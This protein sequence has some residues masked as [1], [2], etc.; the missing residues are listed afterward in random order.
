MST[1]RLY[2]GNLPYNVAE[3]DLVR[4]FFEQGFELKSAKII[5]DTSTWQSKGFGFVDVESGMAEVIIQ[6]MNGIYCENRPMRVDLA[7]QQP[8]KPNRFG[9]QREE[10]PRDLDA[11]EAP[12]RSKARR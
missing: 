8:I 11:E 2:V 7:T 12:R 4:L 6:M 3:S 1:T 10:K 5:Q 9:P